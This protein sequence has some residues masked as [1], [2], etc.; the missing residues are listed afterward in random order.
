MLDATVAFEAMRCALACITS[1]E[2]CRQTSA[3]R[4]KRPRGM[5]C[6]HK[7]GWF[8]V[9]DAAP[10]CALHNRRQRNRTAPAPLIAASWRVSEANRSNT[11]NKSPRS[12]AMPMECEFEEEVDEDCRLC[13]SIG[14]AEPQSHATRHHRTC[15]SSAD[16][17]LRAGCACVRSK[18]EDSCATLVQS[19]VPTC[20]ASRGCV[21]ARVASED[22]VRDA[23]V[24][25]ESCTCFC[26]ISTAAREEEMANAAHAWCVD[27]ASGTSARNSVVAPAT[28]ECNNFAHSSTAPDSDPDGAALN[29][30]A[31]VPPRNR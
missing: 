23:A 11:R 17:S 16:E 6:K 20:E 4:T 12:S 3:A 26:H 31:A 27:A 2:F 15:A 21:N 5:S 14:E 30:G 25:D 9:N 18:N 7:T 13:N 22:D 19:A 1:T 28:S 8:L 24:S 29:N 10:R